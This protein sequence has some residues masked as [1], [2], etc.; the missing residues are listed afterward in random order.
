MKLAKSCLLESEILS[1][2]VKQIVRLQLAIKNLQAVFAELKKYGV[3]L[4]PISI[5]IEDNSKGTTGIRI[6]TGGIRYWMT[7]DEKYYYYEYSKEFLEYEGMY[8]GG[9]G[10]KKITTM[11]D[12]VDFVLGM[13]DFNQN[14]SVVSDEEEED[15]EYESA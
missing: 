5:K 12:V 2:S 8:E 6:V 11:A 14:P 4:Q 10:S 13:V 9:E 1:K 15:C 7:V 3:Y